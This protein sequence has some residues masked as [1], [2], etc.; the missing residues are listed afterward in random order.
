MVTAIGSSLFYTLKSLVERPGEIFSLLASTLPYSTHFYL[1]YFPFQWCCCHL[2]QIQPFSISFFFGDSSRAFRTYRHVICG[3]TR[4]TWPMAEDR[5]CCGGYT[6]PRGREIFC[7]ES[8]EGG[9]KGHRGLRTRGSGPLWPLR[10]WWSWKS[11][12]RACKWY[13]WNFTS[14]TICQLQASS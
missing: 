10:L 8:A 2:L 14:S 4:N 13:F 6:L 5:L 9:W 12:F 3:N 11:G 7:P 1:S